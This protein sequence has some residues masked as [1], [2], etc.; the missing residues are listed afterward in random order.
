MVVGVA[1]VAEACHEVNRVV[2]RVQI[3]QGVT[4]IEIAP[5]WAEISVEMQESIIQGVEGVLGGLQP[6][7][8]HE[9]WCDFKRAHGWTYGEV[10]DEEARTH[11][12]LLPYDELPESQKLKDYV[13]RDV[14]LALA[15]GFGSVT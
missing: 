6:E 3:G 11:P 4:G 10:K 7:A 15:H 14:V 2:Q 12:C 9:A 5:P 1:D 13:F 8:S